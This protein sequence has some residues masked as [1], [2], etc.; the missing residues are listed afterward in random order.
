MMERETGGIP[1][2]YFVT[3][4]IYSFSTLMVIWLNFVTRGIYSFF[5]LMVIWLNFGQ[6]WLTWNRFVGNLICFIVCGSSNMLE[7]KLFE[8]SQ[9]LPNIFLL[10]QHIL[11]WIFGLS[12]C[13][14][15]LS[16][17]PQIALSEHTKLPLISRSL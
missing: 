17:K 5:S 13:L 8:T 4:G 7:F 10:V 16:L 2:N 15:I 11:W 14:I 6:G 12:I 9:K 1:P 3:W